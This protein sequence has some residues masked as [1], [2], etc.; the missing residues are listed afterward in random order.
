MRS[1]EV[2]FIEPDGTEKTIRNLGEDR[3]LMEIAKANGIEGIT[4]D[5]GGGCSCATCHVIVDER[6]W[7]KV[8]LP[9][10]V[11]ETLLDM[12][13][14]VQRPTSRLSCQIRMRNELDGIRLNV[15]PS[16]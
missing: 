16:P 13:S 3:S 12:V 6:W 8:G 14:E 5:C 2:T 11:E 9:D 15:V 1:L 4:A 7:E 10:E